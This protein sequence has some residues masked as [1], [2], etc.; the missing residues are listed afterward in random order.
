MRSPVRLV[1]AAV[2]AGSLVVSCAIFEKEKKPVTPVKPRPPAFTATVMKPPA[3]FELNQGQVDQ[4]VA[5][6]AGRLKGK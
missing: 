5:L 2:L 1:I 3:L 4:R 6:L